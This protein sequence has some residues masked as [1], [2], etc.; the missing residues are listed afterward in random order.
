[1]TITEKESLIARVDAALDEIRPHLAVDGGNVE[2]VDI[3]ENNVVKVK[4]LG[5]CQ[6][7]SMSYMTMKAGLEQTIKGRLPQIAGIEA[8]NGL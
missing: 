1:M 7:C 6:N 5:N 3:T 4:W 2:V 8:I